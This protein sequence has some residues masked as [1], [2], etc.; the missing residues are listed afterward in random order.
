MLNWFF[1]LWKCRP[2]LS[3]LFLLQ[4]PIEERFIDH[5]LLGIHAP[6]TT[7]QIRLQSCQVQL[8]HLL[9]TKGVQ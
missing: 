2:Q 1:S 8:P 6:S 7:K 3:Y 4:V 5:L 9:K